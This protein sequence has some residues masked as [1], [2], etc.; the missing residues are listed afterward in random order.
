MTLLP[1]Q[2]PGP[3][4]PGREQGR[5]RGARETEKVEGPGLVG[6]EEGTGSKGGTGRDLAEAPGLVG[7]GGGHSFPGGPGHLPLPDP[8]AVPSPL[9]AEAVPSRPRTHPP[10]SRSG[11][12]PPRAAVG[13]SDPR[14]AFWGSRSKRLGG[15]TDTGTQK[16]RRRILADRNRTPN[17]S[18]NWGRVTS[19]QAGRPDTC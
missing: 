19:V 6:R 17:G 2:V 16:L 4:R 1:A 11:P 10:R 15:W 8:R 18:E 9:P 3:R 12:G 13:L 14:P 5:E 7:G